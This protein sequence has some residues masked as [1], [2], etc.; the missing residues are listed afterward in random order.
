LFAALTKELP[1][2]R[3]ATQFCFDNAL[4]ASVLKKAHQKAAARLYHYGSKV[5]VKKGFGFKSH[6][7]KINS[8]I[9]NNTLRP[10]K[11]RDVEIG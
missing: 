8:N 9:S 4:D 5:Q 6:S 11:H 3:A 1:L 7:P 2:L 10:A